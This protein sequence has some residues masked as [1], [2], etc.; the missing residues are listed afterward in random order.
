M[1]LFPR[2]DNT[3]CECQSS[4]F[5]VQSSEF[6]VSDEIVPKVCGLTAHKQLL[7]LQDLLLGQ[8]L[9]LRVRGEEG[10]RRGGCEERRVRGEEG[11]RRGEE[12]V[13]ERRGGCEERRV[14]GEEGA[15][16]G[17]CEEG[18]RKVRERRGG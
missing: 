9:I 13:R 16:R 12:G 8:L 2:Y 18:V 17:G 14:R 3:L 1:Q 7:M 6:V 10:V 4:E 11:V 15:R 5:R